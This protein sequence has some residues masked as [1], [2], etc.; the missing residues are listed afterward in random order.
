M[1]DVARLVFSPDGKLL[2]VDYRESVL[3]YEVASGKLRRNL[4]GHA[5]AIRALS[6]AAEAKILA[7]GSAD[8]TALTWDLTG[9]PVSD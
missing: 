7:S 2:A 5:G 9:T 4:A 6:F 3:L 1:G 8:F